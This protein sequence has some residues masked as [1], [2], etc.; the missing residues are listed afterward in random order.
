MNN[1]DDFVVMGQAP[2]DD[3]L[4]SYPFLNNIIGIVA[5]PDHPLANKKISP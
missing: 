3:N 5:P 1:E 4:E 2:E